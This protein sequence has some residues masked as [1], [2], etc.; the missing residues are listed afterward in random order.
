MRRVRLEQL[1]RDV[2]RVVVHGVPLHPQRHE[3][4]QRRPAA[5]A[6]LLDGA[7]RLAVD[8]EHVGAVDD[9]PFEAVRGRPV[10]EVVDAE[11][12]PVRG[13]V[14]VLVV[15]ADEDDREPVDAGQ[16]H[17]LVR[18]AAGHRAVAAPADRDARLAADLERERA[19]DGDGHERRQVAHHRDQ[20]EPDVGHVDVAVL[21]HREPVAAA[22]VLGEDP[23]RLRAAR[24]VDAHV[25]LDRRAH[26]VG[27]HRGRDADRRAL[28]AA[29]GVEAARDLP[30]A[31][32]DVAALLDPAGHEHVAVDLEEILP[33]EVRILDVRSRGNR[34]GF[35]GD[36][37]P[38]Q[39]C[40]RGCVSMSPPD[41]VD[42]GGTMP[43]RCRASATPVP[44]TARACN[45]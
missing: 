28:V 29:S 25:A 11:L 44:A 18:I 16:V 13:G 6:R 17:R 4:E 15:V 32:E 23:P 36:R 45:A 22:H 39:Q 14:G 33:V 37:H 19:A 34:R 31:V 24:D 38:S 27:P 20:A 8:G 35:A 9:D 3:L 40:T 1:A 12:E 43:A 41:W 21:P 42:R 26:V 10:G 5:L 2:E 7:V 30:L